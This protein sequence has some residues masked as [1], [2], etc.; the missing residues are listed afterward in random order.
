MLYILKSLP[1]LVRLIVLVVTAYRGL[2]KELDRASTRKKI[3]N[4][5]KNAKTGN[6]SELEDLVNKRM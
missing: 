4:A 2:S 5:I 1:D 3:E 6:T